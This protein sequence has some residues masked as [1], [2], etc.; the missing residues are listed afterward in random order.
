MKK[1]DDGIYLEIIP[2]PQ[3]QKVAKIDPDREREAR[4][5]LAM[6]MLLSGEMIYFISPDTGKQR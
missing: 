4:V 1:P 3:C 5:T 6:R 2:Y